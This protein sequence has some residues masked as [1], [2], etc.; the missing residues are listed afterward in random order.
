MAHCII[1][2]YERVTEPRACGSSWAHGACRFAGE[3]IRCDASRE[4]YSACPYRQ[5]GRD[6]AVY[7]DVEAGRLRRKV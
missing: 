7:D 4:A 6:V 5:S 3:G 1:G 2:R